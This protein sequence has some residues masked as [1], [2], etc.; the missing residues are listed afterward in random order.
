MSD[1]INDIT[2]V[3]LDAIADKVAEKNVHNLVEKKLPNL[4][5]A[6]QKL[7]ENLILS[8]VKGNSSKARFDE[9]KS[10]FI[11]RVMS[12]YLRMRDSGSTNEILY[13]SSQSIMMDCIRRSVGIS[14]KE[15]RTI[16]KTTNKG[17]GIKGF[18][19]INKNIS[20]IFPSNLPKELSEL[21]QIPSAG[22]HTYLEY[23]K[24]NV[25]KIIF[26][27]FNNTKELEDYNDIAAVSDPISRTS[28]INTITYSDN[29]GLPT[30]YWS[31]A[32]SLVHEAAHIKWDWYH[33]AEPE[34]PAASYSAEIYAYITKYN[35]L[36]SLLSNSKALGLEKQKKN[37]EA[38]MKT[39]EKVIDGY[40]RYLDASGDFRQSDPIFPLLS[41]H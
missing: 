21:L 41:G 11:K 1:P 31:M 36:K 34:N 24:D 23:I 2:S 6:N 25:E 22:G 8:Y 30:P 32:S 13:C 17:M 26:A 3:K 15:I 7:A 38:T 37:I 12:L 16:N 20:V 28:L 35:Y 27:D 39:I 9:L 18:A 14:L 29:M 40:N 33:K 4:E 10:I 5:Y 19:D